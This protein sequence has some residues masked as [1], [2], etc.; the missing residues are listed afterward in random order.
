MQIQMTTEMLA[1][2]SNTPEIPDNLRKRVAGARQ[3]GNTYAVTLSDDEAMD[4][5]RRLAREE[6]LLCGVSSGAAVAAALRLGQRPVMEGCR[7]VVILAS[8]GERYLSTPMFSTAAPLP[9]RRDAQ[10]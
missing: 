3:E 2:L 7:I 5:G 4:V 8:F 6:G 1:A 10:L 9:A